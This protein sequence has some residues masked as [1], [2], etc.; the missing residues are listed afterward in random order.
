MSKMTLASPRSILAATFTAAT[1]CGALA[2]TAHAEEGSG[3][4][5]HGFNWNF[6]IDFGNNVSYGQ[7][8]TKGSG[9]VKE[10]S[11]NDVEG[12]ETEIPV[13]SEVQW[14]RQ[15]LVTRCIC[16]SYRGGERGIRARE[17]R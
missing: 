8:R 7:N 14:M 3:S 12:E 2:G 13:R 10:E 15:L 6:N 1:L 4:K 9:V 11:R 16:T 5:S 17:R